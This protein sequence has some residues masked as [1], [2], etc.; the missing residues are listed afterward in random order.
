MYIN[1][2]MS[3]YFQ[4]EDGTLTPLAYLLIAAAGFTL[5]FIILLLFWLSTGWKKKN[6]KL[7]YD[8]YSS[9]AWLA[10]SS[11]TSSGAV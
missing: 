3:N 10:S 1:T 6:V 4:K 5:L 9:G 7:A 2:N 11:S 8:P